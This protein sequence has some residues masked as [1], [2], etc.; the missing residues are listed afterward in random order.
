MRAHGDV[1][2]HVHVFIIEYMRAVM[3][4]CIYLCMHMMAACLC[5]R[6]SACL[7]SRIEACLYVGIHACIHACVHAHMYIEV[8]L[9]ASN[10]YMCMSV[11]NSGVYVMCVCHL[12]CLM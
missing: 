3:H 2:T 6:M 11:T 10:V 1:R 8:S 9:H 5:S 12:T 4:A 7:H